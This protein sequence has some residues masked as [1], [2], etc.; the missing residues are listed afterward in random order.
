MILFRERLSGILIATSAIVVG[1]AVAMSIPTDR[2]I[3][4][5]MVGR[6]CE[7]AEIRLANVT[8]ARLVAGLFAASAT[9]VLLRRSNQMT[10]PRHRDHLPN[11]S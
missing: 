7:A 10:Q 9:A 1:A 11:D 8:V 6:V 5:G 2:C 4:L 3:D